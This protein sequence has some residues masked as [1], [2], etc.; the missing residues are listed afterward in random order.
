LK[1]KM[2][3]GSLTVEM[4]YLVPII[5]FLF[6]SLVQ[7]TFYFHDKA[8]LAGA[9]YETAVVGSTKMREK[10][11]PDEETLA[12]LCRER[13]GRKC[14]LFSGTTVEVDLEEKEIIVKIRAARRGF[15]VSVEKRAAVTDP[16]KKIRDARK[17]KEF[18]SGAF[19]YITGADFVSGGLP[20]TDA[21]DQ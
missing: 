9:A 14:L 20:D 11:P 17:G 13:I 16:E 12:A 8:V 1:T 21:S 18:A 5:L 2:V 4:S 15:S 6:V 10:E 19:N 3:K 7:A